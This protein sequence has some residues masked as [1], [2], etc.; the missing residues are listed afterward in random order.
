MPEIDVVRQRLSTIWS[1]FNTAAISDTL[2]IIEYLAALLTEGQNVPSLDIR[3]RQPPQRPGLNVDEIKNLLA[4]ATAAAGDKATLFDPYIIF[5][6]QERLRD[7]SG[8]YP[9]PRHIV[10]FMRRLSQVEKQHR[11]IDLACGTGGF[12]VAQEKD[13]PQVQSVTG[14]DNSPE[15]ARIAWTNVTLH[16]SPM[17]NIIVGDPLRVCSEQGEL[18]GK[19]FDRVLMNP[20]FGAPID[21]ELGKTLIG[22]EI[23]GDSATVLTTL[24]LRMLAPDGRAAI[25]VPSGTL[26]VNNAGELGLRGRLIGTTN[27]QRAITGEYH[28]EAV[29]SLPKDA[30]QP[31]STLQT[32]LL[33]IHKLTEQQKEHLQRAI[34]FFQTESDGYPPGRK[35]DI[36]SPPTIIP[37]DL[38]RVEEILLRRDT[39]S[40]NYAVFPVEGTALIGVKQIVLD[41]VVQGAVIEALNGATSFQVDFFPPG[42]NRRSWFVADVVDPADPQHHEHVGISFAGGSGYTLES[43]SSKEQLENRLYPN[44][45]AN[46]R[47]RPI[48][49]LQEQDY[50]QAIAIANDDRVLGVA[51]AP[52]K[53][54]EQEYG[55]QPKDYIKSPCAERIIEPPAILL[56]RVRHAQHTFLEQV[57]G[58]LGRVE[59]RPITGLQLPSPLEADVIPL[60]GLSQEQVWVWERICA[61]SQQHE[62]FNG[63]FT[64]EDFQDNQTAE[65]RETIR[66]TFDL[67]ER[68][69]VIVPVTIVDPQQKETLQTTFYRRIT[70]RD[71]WKDEE[72]V[73]AGEEREPT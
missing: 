49:V 14:I 52:Q 1:R 45:E 57:D 46:K 2:D 12:L 39:E 55:L 59:L 56:G 36:T 41:G 25:L 42:G 32:H 30:L 19:T 62:S 10:R 28:L 4:E 24:A 26:F 35:R 44:I 37:N 22:P 16:N 68:M 51:I 63:L 7:R 8:H 9:T 66:L 23:A 18:Y 13:E 64:T 38:S 70:E 15:W 21:I 11:L 40:A 73:T 60:R 17:A 53:I 43:D 72:T 50:G 33:L 65:M 34:W 54:I 3:P 48:S 27:D 69:G 71:L 6:L 67:F 47:P 29:I 31:Y 61:I 5:R 20:P 58:L